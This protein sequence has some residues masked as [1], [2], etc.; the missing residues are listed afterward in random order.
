MGLGQGFPEEVTSMDEGEP[1]EALRKMAHTQDPAFGSSACSV[2]RERLD[3]IQWLIQGRPQHWSGFGS[4]RRCELCTGGS[5][6]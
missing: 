1:A 2:S 6:G 5:V 3:W 4:C